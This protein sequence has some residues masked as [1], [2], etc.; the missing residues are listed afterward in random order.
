M[1]ISD[2]EGVG[3]CDVVGDCA[4]IDGSAGFGLLKSSHIIQ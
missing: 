4:G 2:S 1:G 3:L